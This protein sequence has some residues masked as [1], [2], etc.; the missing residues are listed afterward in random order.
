MASS[1]QSLANFPSSV[2]GTRT[3]SNCQNDTIPPEANCL[4]GVSTVPIMAPQANFIDIQAYLWN[5][6]STDNCTAE[7]NLRFAY[8]SDPTDTVI[9]RSC[10]DITGLPEQLSVYVFDEAGNYDSCTVVLLLMCEGG[11]VGMNISGDI[12][13]REGDIRD[14]WKSPELVFTEY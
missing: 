5:L 10:D 6:G 8:S 13:N 2:V 9:R 1:F 4:P 11:Q 12:K 14:P 3:L 7:E